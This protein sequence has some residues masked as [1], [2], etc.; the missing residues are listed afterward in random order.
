MKPSLLKLQKF[1][2]LEAERN[3]DNRAVVGG[4]ERMLDT[5]Q[6]EAQAEAPA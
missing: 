2:R 3:Y 1:F 4:L 6:A 5:W